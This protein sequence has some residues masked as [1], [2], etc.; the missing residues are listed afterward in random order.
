MAQRANRRKEMSEMPAKQTAA[1]TKVARRLVPDV[2]ALLKDVQ[3]YR[4][5]NRGNEGA[6]KKILKQLEERAE[7]SSR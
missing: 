7:G 2:K 6:L 5:L 3:T 4:L 1:M